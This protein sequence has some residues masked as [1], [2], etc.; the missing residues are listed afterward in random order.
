MKKVIALLTAIFIMSQA[1]V[2]AASSTVDNKPD[3]EGSVEYD[4]YELIAGYIAD[5]YIDDYY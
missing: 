5:M 1:T 3:I 2:F 4:A